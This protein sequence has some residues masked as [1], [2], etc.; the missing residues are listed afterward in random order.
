MDIDEKIRE[1]DDNNEHFLGEDLDQGKLNRLNRIKS[2]CLEISGMD[3]RIQYTA[4]PFDNRSR[5]GFA[6][7][8]LP[9]LLFCTDEKLIRRL[10][11]LFYA[12][13]FV[14]LSTLSGALRISCGIHDMW[15]KWG[16]DNDAEH[17]E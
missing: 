17:V 16:Y 6:I 4:Y 2:L 12:S 1:W 11:D 7:L 13:D 3:N 10:A 9:K 15:S 5:N 8:D 14:S